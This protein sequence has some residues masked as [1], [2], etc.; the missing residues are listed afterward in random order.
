M[1]GSDKKQIVL[2][3]CVFPEYTVCSVSSNQIVNYLAISL[4]IAY[5]TYVHQQAGKR[6]SYPFSPPFM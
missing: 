1:G 4:S 5:D 6:I 3:F 2:Q